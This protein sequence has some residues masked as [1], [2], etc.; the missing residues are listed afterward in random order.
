MR[1]T[2]NVQKAR[3]GIEETD[4]KWERGKNLEQGHERAVKIFE[5]VGAGLCK[6]ADPHDGICTQANNIQFTG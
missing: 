6:E 4:K 1:R 5:I 2:R 3:S